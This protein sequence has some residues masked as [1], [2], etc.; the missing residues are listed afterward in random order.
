MKRKSDTPKIHTFAEVLRLVEKDRRQGKKIVAT[1][2]CFDIVHVGHIRNLSDAK[3]LGDVLVVGINSDSSVRKN[4][5]PTRPIVP[6]VERAEVIAS[7]RSV[8]YVFVFA[9]RTPFSWIRALRPHIHVKGA[10]A[11]V[12]SHP[13]FP[14]QKKAVEAGG[15]KL[16][17]IE[18]HNGRSTT[19]IV[20]KIQG[21][22]GN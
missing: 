18:H 19:S 16:V 15:G 3:A 22:A 7:L 6:A 8:D 5:G 12:Q 13:D 11:D 1:N 4:K 2:G 10:G 17:L 20:R 14:A 21:G 9:G